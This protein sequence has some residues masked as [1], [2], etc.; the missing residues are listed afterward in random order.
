MKIDAGAIFNNRKEFED[1]DIAALDMNLGTVS[2]HIKWYSPKIQ[3]RWTLIAG[4]QGM[5]QT[6]TNHGEEM[7]IPDATTA[8]IGVL[9]Y[10]IIIIPK[11]RIGRQVCVLMGGISTET[12]SPMKKLYPRFLQILFCL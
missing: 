8:D 10:Q 6:N 9:P 1:G 3:E 4:S 2:Y 12:N 5:Y 11:N 7:L